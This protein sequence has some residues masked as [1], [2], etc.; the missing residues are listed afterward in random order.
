MEIREYWRILRAGWW[1]VALATAIGVAG[2]YAYTFFTT[3]QYQACARLFVTTEGGSSVGEAYQN[4]LFSQERVSSYAGLATSTQV[5]QRAVDQ[6]QLQESAAELRSRITATPIEKTVLLDLCA[7]DAD[8]EVAQALTNAVAGQ[9]TQ[10]VQELETSQRG[11]NPAAG[12]TIV[13]QGD[14]PSAP[15]GMGLFVTLGLGGAIGFVLGLALALLRGLVDRSIRDRP[16]AEDVSG[17]VVLGGLPVD[18]TRPTV[19][20]ASMATMGEPLRVLRTNIRFLGGGSP[21]RVITITSAAS[22]EGRTSTAID[23]AA[24]LAEAGHTVLLVG[25]D[26]RSSTL[27]T[28]LG[29]EQNSGLSTVLSGEHSVEDAIQND[30]FDGVSVLPAGPVPP[31]P[32]ELLGSDRAQDLLQELRADYRYV[33]VDTPPLLDVTDGAILTALSDGTVVLART[34]R[35]TRE[36]LRRAIK[37]LDGVGGIVLGVVTTFEPAG[38][39]LRGGSPAAGGTSSET[40]SAAEASTAPS[41][42]AAPSGPAHA[43]AVRPRPA[44]NDSATSS[45]SRG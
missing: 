17:R 26:L 14:V 9:L 28:R 8:P 24:V 1:I 43:A 45:A 31:N 12:A 11:G 29:I 15:I 10:V 30:V 35:T 22:G 2:G 41:T 44:K 23:L 36:K 3:P 33:I 21:P 6:L 40:S 25:G 4:N 42:E 38:R 5:A 20:V 7:T 13:D 16:R 34:G 18:A 37:A 27:G 19:P 39:R 32:S